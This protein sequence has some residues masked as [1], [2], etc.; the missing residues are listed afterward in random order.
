VNVPNYLKRSPRVVV[1]GICALAIFLPPMIG[2]FGLSLNGSDGLALVRTYVGEIAAVNKICEGIPKGTSVLIVDHNMWWQWGQPIRGM[3]D[4][5]VAGVQTN[6]P[7][8][9]GQTVEPATMVAAVKAIIASGHKPLV[10]APT[11]DE[12][13]PLIAAFGQGTTTF[14]M[15]QDTSI[16]EHTIFGTPHNPVPQRFT[17]YSWEPSK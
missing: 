10:L 16:D 12:F 7:E 11:A 1:T 8:D 3:C 6:P 2:S 17:A 5:P 13:A 4:V 14:L 9:Q 15:A